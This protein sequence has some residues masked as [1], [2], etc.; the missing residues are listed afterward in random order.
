MSSN[1]LADLNP[2][3]QQAV[4]FPQGNLLV[5]AGAG[6]GKTRVLV[7]RIAWLLSQGV[8]LH[9]ILAVTFTNKAATEMRHRLEQMLQCSIAPL[10]VGT[11]HGLAHRLLRLH[12]QEAGL[13][14]SFQII[15]AEDQVRMLK[16]IHKTLALDPEEWPAKQSQRFINNN[17]EKG[18]RSSKVTAQELIDVTLIKIYQIYE[19]ACMRSSLVDFSELLLRSHELWQNNQ[20]LR[21]SYQ[22]RF[23]HILVDEFQDTNAIQYSWIRLLS[24]SNSNLTA[25][26]DD[27]QSIYSWRGADS[28]NMQ[29]L[30]RDYTDVSIVRLEQNYRSTA[31]ILGAA[32]AII[33]YNS[34]RLGKNLWTECGAGELIT[35]YAAGNENDEACYIAD[36]IKLW[37]KQGGE[38]NDVAILYRSNAQSRVIEEKLLRAGISYRVYGGVRFFE[39]TEIKDVL[40]YLR[41]LVNRHDD[42][43]FERVINLP[44]RGLGEVALMSIR[45]HAKLH[46]SSLWQAGKVMVETKQ[47]SAKAADALEGFIRLVEE[48]A[49]QVPEL[50]LEELVRFI[51]KLTNLTAHYSKPQYNEYKQSRL[52][53]L[54]ELITAAE[55][56]ATLIA[57]DDQQALLNSFLAHVALD[58]GDHHTDDSN[59]CVKL[60]TLH[61]A[62]GLEFPV[63]FLCGMEDGLFPHGMSLGE[64]HGLEEERRLCYVGMTRA[65]RKLYLSYASSRRLHGTTNTRRPSRFLQEIPQELIKRDSMVNSVKPALFDFAP[66]SVAIDEF[67]DVSSN[68]SGFSLGQKVFHQSFGEGII[69]GFEGHGEATLVQVKFKR[70]GTK[71]LSPQYAQLQII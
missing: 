9:N 66:K 7:H 61:A 13:D 17:K 25:V 50:S 6:S 24:G 67:S 57:D 40:A 15:D 28:N 58:A 26:G 70:A 55:Q 8:S 5:L 32:N 33:T 41:L 47:L 42:A 46:N 4:T 59:N 54:D 62:K 53:N 20:P 2:V 69:A 23:Q 18:I 65:M 52:E 43:A 71:L 29:R 14:Q 49:K 21:E 27:D 37:V 34:N 60:M 11:F 30:S 63:V 36:K 56:Y 51:I 38:L 16:R 48:G 45:D 1:F 39:R 44:T 22:E 68:Q 19:D 3:Q 31:T 10:W 64:T 12:W 35:L